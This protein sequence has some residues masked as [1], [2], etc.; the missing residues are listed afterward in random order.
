[1]RQ[2]I[3]KTA[4]RRHY[5]EAR[6]SIPADQREDRSDVITRMLLSVDRLECAASVFIYVASGSE[7]QTRGL[8][9][10]CLAMGKTVAVP[11]V[12]S[13][14]AVMRPTVIH[15]WSDLAPGR[16][17]ILEP[18][19]DEKLEPAPGVAIV[20]GLAFTTSGGRLGQGG[21]Y[22]DRYLIAHRDT[23]RI[24]ICFDEQLAERLPTDE[25]DVAMD[26]VITG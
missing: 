19:T 1:M 10:S 2:A 3:D 16:F 13:G 12:E 22:Y 17:G 14:Q 7:V 20:P 26:E 21:G 24:G 9:E 15:A 11:R 25:H 6:D 18:T 8:I 23:Y 4:L 5:R